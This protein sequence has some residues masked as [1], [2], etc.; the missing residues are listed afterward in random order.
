MAPN[1]KQ[2]MIIIIIMVMMMM[3]MMMINTK[4]IYKCYFKFLC[5]I[6]M[7]FY[8]V[9][10]SPRDYEYYQAQVPLNLTSFRDLWL[11]LNWN[12][13]YSVH[14][15]SIQ[16]DQMWY[17]QLKIGI[18]CRFNQLKPCVSLC[19]SV[20][21]SIHLSIYLCNICSNIL[22]TLLFSHPV[23]LFSYYIYI[24]IN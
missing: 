11:C 4:H 17:T 21:L 2:V 19:L 7:K 10:T 16:F 14:E 15:T 12:V 6:L 23:L 3:M 8:T 1:Q 13:T 18:S 22:K 9:Y 20:C 5:Y 24:Y